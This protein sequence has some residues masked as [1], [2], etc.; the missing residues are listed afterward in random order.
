MAKEIIRVSRKDSVKDLK[1]IVMSGHEEGIITFGKDL[2]EAGNIL[3]DY[4]FSAE[5]N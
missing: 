1:I 3:L 4:Y 5:N 2:E